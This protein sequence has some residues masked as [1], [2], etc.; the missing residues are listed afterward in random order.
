M[1]EKIGTFVDSN[2]LSLKSEI[3]MNY[4]AINHSDKIDIL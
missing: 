1:V 2:R 4:E 3:N